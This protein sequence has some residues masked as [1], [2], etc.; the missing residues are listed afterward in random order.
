MFLAKVVNP[1]ITVAEAEMRAHYDGHRDDYAS[2][3]MM[4]LDGVAFK[5][6]HDAEAAMAKALKG[7]EL[8]WLRANAEGQID[9]AAS[10]QMLDLDG[11]P[12]ATSTMPEGLRA[13]LAGASSGDLRFYAPA[14]GP[15]YVVQVV[16]RIAP[17]PRPFDS[18]SE[19]ISQKLYQQK[20]ERALKDWVGKLRKAS[21]IE[22]FATGDALARALGLEVANGS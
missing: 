2:P 6:R 15:Y 18:V 11:S 21:E 22:V 5:A 4:R 9:A 19:E 20:Q 10:E 14:D 12:V 1:D 3:E 16:S 8:R 13:A 17:M 7:T